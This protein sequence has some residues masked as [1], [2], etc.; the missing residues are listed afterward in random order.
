MRVQAA[1]TLGEGRGGAGN[2][3]EAAGT[4][5]A[6]RPGA[7]KRSGSLDAQA[8]GLETDE[9]FARALGSYDVREAADALRRYL[10]FELQTRWGLW[11]YAPCI[12]QA[13]A[14]ADA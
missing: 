9:D 11:V 12:K 1:V 2:G 7:L 3:R 4:Q 8:A 5:G 14:D 6:V 10:A 13:G